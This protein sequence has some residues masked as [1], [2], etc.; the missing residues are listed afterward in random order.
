MCDQKL[1]HA[2][3][4]RSIKD[5]QALN[6][7]SWGSSPRT[8]LGFAPKNC[9][10]SADDRAKRF[11]YLALGVHYHGAQPF[12]ELFFCDNDVMKAFSN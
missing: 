11:C 8:D 1:L 9:A 10:I 6:S 12:F 2:G 7:A 4:D 5:W 3:E